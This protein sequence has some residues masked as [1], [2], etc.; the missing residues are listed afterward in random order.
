MRIAAVLLSLMVWGV[1][2]SFNN[3]NPT[4]TPARPIVREA[5]YVSDPNAPLLVGLSEILLTAE[6]AQI[7]AVLADE[8]GSPSYVL[9]PANQPGVLASTITLDDYPLG[10]DASTPRLWVVALR[11]SAY[12]IS[13]SLGQATIASQLAT[14]FATLPAELPPSPLA[15]LVAAQ[16]N[17]WAWFGEIEVLGEMVILLDE[18]TGQKEAQSEGLQLRYE[19]RRQA[20]PT[21]TPLLIQ[22]PTA[23][24]SPTPFNPLG[25]RRVVNETFQDAQS[26]VSWFIGSDPIYSANIINGAYQIVLNELEPERNNIALSWGSIQNLI[27]DNYIIRARMRVLQA[28]VIARYGLWL[29]YQDDFNFVFFGVEN[30]GRY[31]VA[32]FQTTY[33][34]LAPWT[35]SPQVQTGSSVNEMIVEVQGGMYTLK[36]NGE[37]L[38]TTSDTAFSEGRVAFFCYAESVPATCHLEEL[39]VWIPESAPF[40]KPTATPPD[41]D[42]Q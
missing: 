7:L 8:N 24:L 22:A 17:L 36:L 41:D 20:A 14:G 9:Y 26:N 25:Y 33:T 42:P 4:P 3:A 12:P 39:E 27:F 6:D 5:V 15:L 23:A 40:P 19:V 28:D 35:N 34:E 31:R 30:T 1:G 10:L 13:E 16:E 18:T 2:C 37:T 21:A 38:I 32:R 29:H 11:H